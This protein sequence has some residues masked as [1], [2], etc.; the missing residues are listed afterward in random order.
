MRYIAFKDYVKLESAI[1]CKKK[2]KMYI[3]HVKA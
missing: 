3:S 2:I 1:K